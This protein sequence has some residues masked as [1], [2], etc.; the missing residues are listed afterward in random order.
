MK[1]KFF[2]AL[3][4]FLFVGFAATAQDVAFGPKLG[5]NLTEI[6]VNDPEATYKGRTGYH[7]G[8][9]LRGRFGKVAVQPE[10][11]LYTQNGE[12][13]NAL[14]SDGE[15]S[16]TYVTVPVLFKFYPVMGLNFQLGPQVG[17]LVDGE[18][19]GETLLGSFKQ[20]IKDQYKSTD[21]S[22][23]VGAGWDFKFGLNIDARYN[24]GIADI[25]DAANGGEAKSRV[26]LISVGW[27]FLK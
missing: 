17:F 3:S 15:E 12:F 24:I 26:F 21:F 7:A 6:D 27:N 14:V 19:T 13:E 8:I 1:T 20:D 18:R 10:L 9:F 23:S 11:L 4:I 16:F 5:I 25:N 2:Y 22:V